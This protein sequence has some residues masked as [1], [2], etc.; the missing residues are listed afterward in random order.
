[1]AEKKSCVPLNMWELFSSG[2]G[3]LS[4]N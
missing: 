4:F 2:G 1:M 3:E